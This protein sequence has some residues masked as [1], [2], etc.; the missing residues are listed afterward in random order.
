LFDI[1]PGGAIFRHHYI[2]VTALVGQQK[3]K[4]PV[5]TRHKCAFIVQQ[6]LLRPPGVKVFQGFSETAL[7]VDH[8][9]KNYFC[10]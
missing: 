3:L 7:P 8:F 9:L 6:T 5:T 2:L 4:V 10:Y 1:D